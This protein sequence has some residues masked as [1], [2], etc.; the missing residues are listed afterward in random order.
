METW[1]DVV[2]EDIKPGAYQVS[3]LGRVRNSKGQ[4]IKA[5]ISNMGYPRINFATVTPSGSPAQRKHMVHRIVAA[6]F[7]PRPPGSDVVNHLDGVKDNNLPSNLEWTTSSGNLAHAFKT[8]L[9]TQDG[10]KNP[11]S[12]HAA[13]TVEMICRLRGDGK[14]PSQIVDHCLL[15]LGLGANDRHRI[16]VLVNHVVSGRRWVSVSSK[17]AWFKSLGSTT[18]P[19]GSTLQAIGGG[20]TGHPVNAG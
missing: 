4:I 14:T 10:D 16:K 20:N 12:V 7:V 6:A 9:R 3:D 13:E 1:K 8:R 5:D 15:E 2:Y 18:I 19:Q 17:Y 11:S